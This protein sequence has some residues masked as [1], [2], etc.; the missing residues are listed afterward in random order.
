MKQPVISN[1]EVQMRKEL[2][3]KQKGLENLKEKLEYVRKY[4][5][6]QKTQVSSI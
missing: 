2:S 4:S 3:A 5:T 1:A 6:D